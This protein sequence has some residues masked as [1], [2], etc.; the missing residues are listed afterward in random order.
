MSISSGFK[1]DTCSIPGPC[2]KVE[3]LKTVNMTE[4]NCTYTI[5]YIASHSSRMITKVTISGI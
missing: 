3:Y 5:V 2:Q 1:V 4:Y